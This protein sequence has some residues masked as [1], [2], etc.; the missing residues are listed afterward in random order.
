MY[1][2]D[3]EISDSSI[4]RENFDDYLIGCSIEG[5]LNDKKIRVNFVDYA[6]SAKINIG[7]EFTIYVNEK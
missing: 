7:D 5:Y 1:I 4:K 2:C 3:I 6:S